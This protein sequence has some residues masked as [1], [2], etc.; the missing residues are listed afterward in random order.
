KR[1]PLPGGVTKD[2][3][4][5]AS[6]FLRAD[7][8]RTPFVQGAK[9][10]INAV[11]RRYSSYGTDF[12]WLTALK[13]SVVSCYRVPE[14]KSVR[15]FDFHKNKWRKKKLAVGD[16]DEI[17]PKGAN[18]A[19]GANFIHSMDG[20]GGHLGMIALA[21]AKE[22]IPLMTIHDCFGCVAPHVLRLLNIVR[23]TFNE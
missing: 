21:A 6:L 1:G 3:P 22:N 20:V 5:L 4:K 8:K 11:A 16:K 12:R 13:L 14:T 7:N 19:A 15:Y 18:R 2:A 23:P 9:R 17:E 10:F